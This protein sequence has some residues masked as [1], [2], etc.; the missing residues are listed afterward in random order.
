MA[1]SK[2]AFEWQSVFEKMWEEIKPEKGWSPQ[3]IEGIINI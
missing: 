2:L 1:L 3:N